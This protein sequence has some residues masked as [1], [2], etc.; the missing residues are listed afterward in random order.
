MEKGTAIKF[1]EVARDENKS[2]CCAAFIMYPTSLYR[3]LTFVNRQ[4][5][6]ALSISV[7]SLPALQGT[8]SLRA[9]GYPYFFMH[10]SEC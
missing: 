4:G 1:A 7:S 9:G 8:S 5:C 3:V 10:T 6:S 2:R